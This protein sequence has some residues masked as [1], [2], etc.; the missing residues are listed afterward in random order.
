MGCIH[1]FRKCALAAAL[2]LPAVCGTTAATAATDAMHCWVT[3]AGH[4]Q[5]I[6]IPITDSPYTVEAV[7]IGERFRFKALHVKGPDRVERIDIYVYRLD[8]SNAVLIQHAQRT[9]P[10]PVAANGRRVDL[11]GEQHLYSGPLERELSYQ[12]GRGFSPP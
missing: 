4:T 6:P 10:W 11:V 7:E 8:E 2:L 9:P 12:C 1:F 3:Y 5:R